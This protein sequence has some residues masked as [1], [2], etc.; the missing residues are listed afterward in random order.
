M[1]NQVLARGV[2]LAAI[3][4]AFG[5][6]AFRYPIGNLMHAGPGLFP[7]TVS[8][9]LMTIALLTI[10]RSLL[11]THSPV[12][13]DVRNIG[14]ILLALVGFVVLTSYMGAIAG[15]VFL[16]FV[17]S[18]AG[19]SYSWRRN[20]LVSAALAAIAFAFDHLL[21]LTLPLV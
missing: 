19:S 13:F 11:G 14:L 1:P 20:I 3:A 6:N 16:V 12:Q 10:T 18:A 5:L 4:A 9:G 21:G 15:I 8:G 17:A 2:W 7:L